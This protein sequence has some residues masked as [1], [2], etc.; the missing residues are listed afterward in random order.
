VRPDNRCRANDVI[1]LVA[2]RGQPRVADLVRLC[3]LA[4]ERSRPGGEGGSGSEAR[5]QAS[6]VLEV[7]VGALNTLAAIAA[8][9][10]GEKGA[11]ALFDELIA[12]WDGTQG[13]KY[14]KFGYAADAIEQASSAELAAT[15]ERIAHLRSVGHDT[16]GGVADDTAGGVRR[17]WWH[18]VLRG[19]AV[20]L[21]GLV[22]A[23][24]TT[25]ALLP[26][27]QAAGR[28]VV[29]DSVEL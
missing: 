15:E 4:R 8:F 5:E 21:A 24:A 18:S 11:R 23:L 22:L 9:G 25:Q 6:R 17:R 16:A 10:G 1:A 2:S 28:Q 20:Q 12:R 27:M 29:Q 13:A 7:S 26:V 19:F 14:A 3:E